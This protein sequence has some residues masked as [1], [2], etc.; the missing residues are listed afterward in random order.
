MRY[1]VMFLLLSV[2]ATFRLP[3]LRTLVR[4]AV[5]IALVFG[6]LLPTASAQAPAGEGKGKVVVLPESFLRGYDPITIFFTGDTGPKAGGPEDHPERVVK[7]EPQA[8]GEYRWVDAR[9]LL[10]RP[11]VPWP[12]LEKFQVT[13][14]GAVKV[15]HTLMVRPTGTV[16][17]EGAADL[18]ALDEVTLT[19]SEPLPKE[20][21]ARMTSFEIRP[22]PGTG[23][24]GIRY[25]GSEGFAVKALERASLGDPVSYAIR[26]KQP[27]GGG[28]RI[29]LKLRLSSD[30]KAPDSNLQ[31]SFKTQVPF[32]VSAVGCAAAMG[33][34]VSD[35]SMNGRGGSRP[36]QN[37]P[38]ISA[39]SPR[40]SRKSMPASA[41]RSCL[42]LAVRSTPANPPCSTASSATTSAGSMS[43]RKP[44][45]SCA[46]ASANRRATWRPPRC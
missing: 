17:R 36:D 13:A 22:L 20:K 11:A 38:R 2:R 6:L 35:D 15:L 12:A 46:T 44:T 26:L 25:L 19:F 7:L 42:S 27:I 30:E 24:K 9:T 28:Y 32:R 33:F 40:H 23:A 1:A 29:L 34:P 10:F 21:L 31:F 4:A 41:H 16:P 37:A 14:G 43:S 45:A 18:A 8:P 5:G 3:S 39:E